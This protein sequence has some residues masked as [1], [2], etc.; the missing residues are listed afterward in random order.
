MRWHDDCLIHLHECDARQS[1]V[2]PPGPRSQPE[3]IGRALAGGRRARPPTREPLMAFVWKRLLSTIPSLIGVVV[4]TFFI[5][6][7]LPG[8]PAAFFAGPAANADSIANIRTT[9]G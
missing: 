9:L 7:A 5:S 8:D 6:H 3:L 2:V 4:L 1:R